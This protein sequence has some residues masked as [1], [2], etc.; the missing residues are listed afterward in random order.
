MKRVF[1]IFALC[2]ILVSV[3]SHAVPGSMPVRAEESSLSGEEA[4]VLTTVNVN[5][6][7]TVHLTVGEKVY[8]GTYSTWKE[9]RRT[10]LNLS[11]KRRSPEAMKQNSWRREN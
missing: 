5:D 4:A 9:S 7:E 1:A 3:V 11:K 10:V 2:C 8:Y 6:T